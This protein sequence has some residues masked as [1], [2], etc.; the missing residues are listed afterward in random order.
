MARIR[1]VLGTMPVLLR[2]IVRETVAAQTDDVEIL[3]EVAT[4][5]EIA[6]AVRR[7]EADVAVVGVEHLDW[8]DLRD[9]L[10]SLL[11]EHPR[12]SVIALANDGR[13]GWIYRLR[14]SS[15]AIHDVSPAALVQAIRAT[16]TRDVH[17]IIHPFSAR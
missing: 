15:A 1:V 17:P 8:N 6:T 14:P 7:T 5:G 12:L 2:D 13:D 3:A 9:F 4:R 11:A 10:H 16:T